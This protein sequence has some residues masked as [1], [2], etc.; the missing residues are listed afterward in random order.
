MPYDG[1]ERLKYAIT[2]D[3][4]LWVTL[5][6]SSWI[7]KFLRNFS[8]R[9]CTGSDNDGSYNFGP[10]SSCGAPSVVDTLSPLLARPMSEGRKEGRTTKTCHSKI[11]LLLS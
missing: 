8:N 4:H 11:S 10:R 9:S 1:I 2:R 3:Y 5:V 6:L 7:E